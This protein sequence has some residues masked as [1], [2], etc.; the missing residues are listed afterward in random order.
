MQSEKS[1]ISNRQLVFLLIAYAQSLTLT[2]SFP[3]SVARQDTWLAALVGGALAVP[4]ALL[5]AAL[6]KRWAGADLVRLNDAVF[7]GFAGRLVTLFYLWYFFQTAIHFMYFFNT[8]WITYI[9]PE[10]PRSVFLIMF[11][12]VCALAVRSGLEVLTRCCFAFSVLVWTTTAVLVLLLLGNMH[13]KYLLPALHTPAAQMAEGTAMIFAIPFD[14]SVVLMIYPGARE[15]DRLK[16]P[17]FTAL[18]VSLL[19]LVVVVLRDILVMG[20]RVANSMSTSFDAARQVNLAEVLTRMDV[21]VAITL[22]VTV[23]VRVSLLYYAVTLGTARFFGL[24]D[25]RPLVVP[26]G[27]LLVGLGIALYPSDMEQSLAARYSWPYNAAV[28]QVLLPL[29]T[30]VGGGIRRVFAKAREA[31]AG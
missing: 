12:I 21:L 9:M 26:V 19:H 18:G 14:F 31:N 27:L 17:L 3:F 24:P 11:A 7:G 15:P 4:V 2:V 5:Y 16:K 13:A 25:Y 28:C 10:T 20:P 8:F 6:A 1:V 30:L 22:L 29:A 23:F